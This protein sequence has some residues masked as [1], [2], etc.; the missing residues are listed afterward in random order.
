MAPADQSSIGKMG[1]A[2][3]LKLFSLKNRRKGLT[4]EQTNQHMNWGA[5]SNDGPSDFG[6]STEPESL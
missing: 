5:K 1:Y 4:K 6:C 2:Y 3:A